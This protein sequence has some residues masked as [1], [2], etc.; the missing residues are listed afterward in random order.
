M[1]LRGSRTE[2]GRLPSGSVIP[3]QQPASGAVAGGDFARLLAQALTL[4]CAGCHAA[5]AAGIAIMEQ[6]VQQLG[7][8]FAGA[9][10][11]SEDGSAVFFNPGAMARIH[12]G[13]VSGAGYV[14]VPSAQFHDAGSRQAPRL[15]GAPLTGG[16]GGDAGVTTLVPNLYYVQEVSE[17]FVVGL[18]VNAPFGVHSEYDPT[19]QG[20]YQ[21]VESLIDTVNVNP[22]LAIRV[23][24]QFSLGAG[25]NIQYF[26]AKLTNAIDFGAVCVRAVGPQACAQAG[27]APQR[28]DGFLRVEG[29]GV[30]VG[31]NLGLLYSPTAATQVGI[32]YRSGINQSLTGDAD[33]SVPMVAAPLTR[34]GP[35]S[36]TGIRSPVQLPDSVLFGI[37]HRIDADWVLTADALWTHWSRV[38]SLSVRRAAGG[39]LSEQV[40]DWQDAW[41]AALGVSYRLRPHMKLRA[42]VAYDESP[43][44]SASLR[45]PSI[46]D[47]DRIWL[48]AGFTW[49]VLDDVTLHGGYAH[50]FFQDAPI[51][52]A[53]ASGDW[54]IGTFS[55][56]LDIAGLQ[57]DWR[58]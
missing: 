28:A 27:L 5:S 9:A 19:W 42:G 57:F 8:A 44:P 17:R 22:S 33:F 40:L 1:F 46:P 12:G 26:H 56:R 29:D 52:H 2:C 14:I 24:E 3:V 37:Q 16:D 38:E 23:N 58:F 39:R 18:G 7:Q 45:S 41:R 20:R 11:N 10:T 54:L 32:G 6:S 49:Q 50:L 36:D 43:I 34:R 4:M 47:S 31:Y 48:T 55:D 30:G 35:F 15:G 21:A 25:F 51:R 13:L 53:G